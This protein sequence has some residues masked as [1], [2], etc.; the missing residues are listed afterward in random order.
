MAAE[1]SEFGQEASAVGRPWRPKRPNLDGSVRRWTPSRLG[2]VGPRTFLVRKWTPSRARV[3]GRTPATTHGHWSRRVFSITRHACVFNAS[4]A[5]SRPLGAYL[6]SPGFGSGNCLATQFEPRNNPPVARRA[7]VAS[8]ILGSPP[9]AEPRPAGDHL[10]RGQPEIP[11]GLR[12][13]G[14]L[15]RFGPV[16]PLHR[17]GQGIAAAEG[18]TL[19][20]SQLK[21]RVGPPR[22]SPEARMAA[23]CRSTSNDANPRT[24]WA[25]HA[26]PVRTTGRGT[27]DARS[28]ER[29][30]GAE[31]LHLDC[32]LRLWRPQRSS[33]VEPDAEPSRQQ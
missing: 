20:L 11:L 2:S 12:R 32:D 30:V 13:V 8:T 3:H 24:H 26:R 29:G 5:R 9:L 1:T 28:N 7:A 33:P 6:G 17:A 14:W 10:R 16:C 23:G 15:W 22:P 21:S 18:V 25:L 27:S 4:R 19:L 31:H